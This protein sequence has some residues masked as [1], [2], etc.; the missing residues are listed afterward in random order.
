MLFRPDRPGAG[1][2]LSV[3]TALFILLFSASSASA[4][5]GYSK[6]YAVY[7]IYL[8][9]LHVGDFTLSPDIAAIATGFRASPKSIRR[10]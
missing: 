8:S 5:A 4:Q 10:C 1:F 2:T 9:G 3:A 7:N 6:I